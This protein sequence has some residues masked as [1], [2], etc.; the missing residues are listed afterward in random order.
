MNVSGELIDRNT[1]IPF[2][3]NLTKR[4]D[5]MSAKASELSVTGKTQLQRKQN[6]SLWVCLS[7]TC[8]K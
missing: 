8:K 3:I 1:V 5:A 4:L 7:V 6:N 2:P